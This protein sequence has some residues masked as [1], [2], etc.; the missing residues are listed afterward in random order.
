MRSIREP[1]HEQQPLCESCHLYLATQRCSL[2]EE[3]EFSGATQLLCELCAGESD[4]LESASYLPASGRTAKSRGYSRVDRECRKKVLSH[5]RPSDVNVYLTVLERCDNRRRLTN[6]REIAR[7]AGHG[8]R[9]V[10]VSLSYLEH[11]GLIRRL[12]RGNAGTRI[13]IVRP[14]ASGRGRPPRGVL[15]DPNVYTTAAGRLAATSPRAVQR[16]LPE[17]L[18]ATA[19]GGPHQP[20]VA[21]SPI[22][23]NGQDPSSP[24]NP[25]EEV[26]GDVRILGPATAVLAQRHKYPLDEIRS[27]LEGLLRLARAHGEPVCTRDLVEYVDEQLSDPQLCRDLAAGAIRFPLAV[28]TCERRWLPWLRAD[29]RHRQRLREYREH[30]KVGGGAK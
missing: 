27:R 10:R 3:G 25:P 7:E 11:L 8:E 29:A 22:T 16:N 9:T 1:H 15:L 24:P 2:D 5:L 6:T 30:L 20:P 21:I 13:L 17:R 18:P 4:V 12:K 23:K 19:E 28:A 26:E 14:E